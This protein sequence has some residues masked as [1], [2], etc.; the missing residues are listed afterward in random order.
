MQKISWV[1]QEIEIALLRRTETRRIVNQPKQSAQLASPRLKCSGFWGTG[2]TGSEVLSLL[3]WLLGWLVGL[4]KRSPETRANFTH[5]ILLCNLSQGT[6][7]FFKFL[8]ILL[9]CGAYSVQYSTVQC[10]TVQCSTVQYS[11]VQ[12]STVEWSGVECSTVKYGVYLCTMYTVRT[13]RSS[14]CVQYVRK[15]LSLLI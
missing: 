5:L 2:S 1:T 8:S 14:A 11:A 12:Y 13:T 7:T 10:S 4:V 15:G 9:P 3:G 6:L